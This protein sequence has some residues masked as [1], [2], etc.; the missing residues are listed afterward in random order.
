MVIIILLR[1]AKNCHCAGVCASKAHT[2]AFQLPAVCETHEA[3]IHSWAADIDRRL[4]YG[5]VKLPVIKTHRV[6]AIRGVTTAAQN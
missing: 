6:K 3:R 5:I 2:A 1:C 4:A